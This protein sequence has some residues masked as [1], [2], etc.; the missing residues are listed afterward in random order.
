MNEVKPKRLTIPILQ[1]R[2]DQ[3]FSE[4]I[5]LRDANDNG[6][7]RCITCGSMWRWQAIQNGHYIDRR[8]IGARYDDRNCN[9]QCSSCNIGLRGNLDKY[10][11]AIIEKHGVKVLE[12]LEATKRSSE[13]WT[14]AD[15]QEKITYYKAEVKR[16]RKEKGL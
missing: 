5:R 3:I 2:L 9:P 14:T 16:I 11:R 4:Y 8:H 7:C 6:F 13:K 15:Y 10:K 1:Q 12:E